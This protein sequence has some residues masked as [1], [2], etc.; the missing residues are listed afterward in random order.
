MGDQTPHPS[1]LPSARGFQLRRIWTSVTSTV[2]A[3]CVLPIVLFLTC[4]QLGWLEGLDFHPGRPSDDRA[5]SCVWLLVGVTVLGCLAAGIFAW[6]G[7][8]RSVDE[9][10]EPT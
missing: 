4:E 7:E 10:D 9:D 6:R 5:E 1:D 8:S 2:A 3:G